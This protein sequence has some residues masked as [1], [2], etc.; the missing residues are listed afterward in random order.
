MFYGPAKPEVFYRTVLKQKLLRW[1]AL[2]NLFM[3]LMS[4]VREKEQ[5][6]LNITSAPAQQRDL[7]EF[8]ILSDILWSQ[9]LRT[10]PKNRWDMK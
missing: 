6:L 10:Q 1:A 9:P 2:K 4:F 3:H 5:L 7:E 8:W